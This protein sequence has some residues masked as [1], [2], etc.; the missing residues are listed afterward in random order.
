MLVEDFCDVLCCLSSG[1]GNGAMQVAGKLSDGNSAANFG[2]AAADRHSAAVSLTAW[3]GFGDS[4][5][6]GHLAPPVGLF[7]NILVTSQ[8]S[9][10]DFIAPSMSTEIFGQT[11][12]PA[13]ADSE[14]SVNI[15][16]T[17]R[18]DPV[19]GTVVVPT[20][21]GQMSTSVAG[22]DQ[23]REGSSRGATGLQGVGALLVS[24]GRHTCSVYTDLS[25]LTEDEM[26]QFK[27]PRFVL[28]KIPI[29]PPAKELIDI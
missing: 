17:F 18:Q 27:A 23:G 29:R 25:E 11:A 3:T 9:R 6:T 21:F 16:N 10:T 1:F 28:G 14:S 13:K 7:S 8:H 4:G 12:L 24:T 15:E 26:R 22:Q 20:F 2:T 19:S 5:Q